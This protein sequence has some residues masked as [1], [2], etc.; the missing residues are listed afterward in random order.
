MS[1]IGSMFDGSKGAGFNAIGT[2]VAQ[3]STEDQANQ[4][5]AA[6]Q[7]ALQQ[8]QGMLQALQ[9]Q[10]G[11]QNQSQVYNQ[12]QGIANGTGPNPAQNALNQNTATNIANQAALMGSQRGAGQN[13]GLLAR[14]AAMQGANTQQQAVG[15]GATLQAQQQMNAINSAGQLANQQVGNLANANSAY[16]Q[17]AQGNRGLTL[18]GIQ[19]QNNANVSMQTGVNNANA[20]IAAGNQKFQ[21][22]L[23]GGAINGGASAIMAANHGGKIPRMADG[24]EVSDGG[25]TS[26]FGKSYISDNSNMLAQPAPIAQPQAASSGGGSPMDSIMKM[27]PMLL[28]A[29]SGGKVPVIVSPGE[30][31]VPKDNVK[32]VGSGKA[33][34]GEAAHM[35]PGKAK[36]AGDS[37][38]NDTVPMQAEEGAV[39]I[40]RSIMNSKD[41]AKNAADFVAKYMAK[42]GMVSGK[43]K[44]K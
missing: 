24:G 36:V 7:Q 32:A 2:H 9:G 19:G 29:N 38:K 12:L 18:N 13:V 39:V 27:A 22:D 34:L 44:A 23:V 35:I 21:N 6:S 42:G 15:Q 33:S 31:I 37:L 30:A 3:P 28:A 17:A 5:Y 16:N 25:P 4:D 20:G 26:S 43:K 41:P 10:N 8:Q 40:P 14:Q 11:I 1:F